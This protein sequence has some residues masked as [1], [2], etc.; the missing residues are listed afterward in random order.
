MK[1]LRFY[2]GTGLAVLLLLAGCASQQ[3]ISGAPSSPEQASRQ[4][5]SSERSVS[6]NGRN[7]TEEREKTE[8]RALTPAEGKPVPARIMRDM[9]FARLAQMKGEP[10]AAYRTL[11]KLVR[12][13]PHPDLARMLYEFAEEW[14]EPEA[15]KT[16]A[17]LW[18][19]LEAEARRPWQ[20]LCLLNAES[21]HEQEALRAFEGWARLTPASLDRDL[22]QVGRMALEK[23]D[24]GQAE[25]FLWALRQRYEDRWGSR[26][27]W[28]EYLMEGRSEPDKAIEVL[29]EALKM[30]GE[31]AVIN[32]VL[33]RAY[34]RAGR[35]QEGL[36]RLAQYVRHHPEDWEMQRGY[37]ALEFEQGAVEQA[38]MR[39]EKLLKDMDAANA[40]MSDRARLTLGLIRMEQGRLAEARRLLEP[41]TAKPGVSQK[42]GFYLGR[43]AEMEGDIPTA[44]GYY[45]QIRDP[46]LI[47][48]AQLSMVRILG[49]RHPDRALK[50]L[51]QL[52]QMA[53]TPM[54]R[55]EVLM[56]RAE[57][58]QRQGETEA[59]L[60]AIQAAEAAAEGQ[61]DILHQIAMHEE[62]LGLKERAI[63]L[64]ERLVEQHPDHV[65]LL[66]TLGYLYLTQGAP[67]EKAAPLVEKAWRLS[68]KEPAI[69]DTL[70]VLRH[71]QGRLQEARRW[72]ERAWQAMH[73]SYSVTRL[74]DPD[75][76][77]VLAHLAQVY[78]DLK[79]WRAFE[80]LRQRHA[81]LISRV[82]ALQKLV[83]RLQ[84]QRKKSDGILDF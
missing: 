58:L 82:P 45:T 83:D 80:R 68:P 39:L 79:D 50:V 20:I 64:L 1:T 5:Q 23:L 18:A 51:T 37:A 12:R 33:A 47:M 35:Q 62:A 76:W 67:V 48:P 38:A 42:A 53:D 56:L 21:G 61:P 7:V 72:L 54:E 34:L 60:K 9:M 13:Y 24:P 28:A 44:L 70:G 27:A 74:T 3:T 8:T 36:N 40:K 15:M 63:R 31:P 78:A 77:V 32:P 22:I 29:H 25:R 30:Q 71:R 6:S 11:L 14:D 10:E 4:S 69:W 16:A 73:A 55:V 41:L 19:Q 49:R 43:I 17:R 59:A 75:N 84:R 66:N 26:V 81:D 46:R 57:L 52:E 2:R 65:A